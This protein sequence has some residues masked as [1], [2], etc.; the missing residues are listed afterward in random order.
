MYKTP[1]E[2]RLRLLAR[3]RDL[4]NEHGIDAIGVRDLARD[5][6]L[7]PGNVSYHF[8]RKQDLVRALMDELRERNAEAHEGAPNDGTFEGFLARTRTIFLTQHAYRCLAGSIVHVT[9][10]YPE[11][12]RDYRT[13]DRDRRRSLASQLRALER[14]GELDGPEDEAGLARVVGT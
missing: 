13:V 8:P 1:G 3:A 11:I 12:A 10:A 9:D 5:L 7:S 14:A 6:D 2:T 4:W